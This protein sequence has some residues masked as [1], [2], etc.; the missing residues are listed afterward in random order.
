MTACQFF[1]VG[2]VLPVSDI[3]SA[4]RYYVDVLGFTEDFIMEGHGSVTRGRVGIQ[5]TH[6]SGNFSA[7]SYPGWIYLFVEG[8]DALYEVYRTS[9]IEFTRPLEDH[10]HG[11][12][13]F[14]ITDL[15]GFHLR[16]GQYLTD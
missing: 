13:E 4:V 5:F 12:R 14:E 2:P 10:A 8:I 7:S 16:F 1:G 6:A 15:N 3:A 11:M 9:G